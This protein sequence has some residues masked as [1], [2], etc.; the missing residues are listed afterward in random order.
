MNYTHHEFQVF[1]EAINSGRLLGIQG[2]HIHQFWF[3]LLVLC[4][5]TNMREMY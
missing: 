4:Q 5:S 2:V 3:V 1:R